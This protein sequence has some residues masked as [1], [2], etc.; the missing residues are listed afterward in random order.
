MPTTDDA[1]P[2]PDTSDVRP[3]LILVGASVRSAA[4]LAVVSGLR[5]VC[6]DLFGDADLRLL[7]S[8]LS[9]AIGC[10][11]YRQIKRFA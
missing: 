3:N 10:Q 8:G 5:P 7:L 2:M 9:W 11:P 1:H 6:V 4:Q